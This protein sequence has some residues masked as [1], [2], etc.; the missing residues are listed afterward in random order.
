[1]FRDGKEAQMM[2]WIYG[3]DRLEAVREEEGVGRRKA[4]GLEHAWPDMEG[5]RGHLK[6][7]SKAKRWKLKTVRSAG[8]RAEGSGRGE[9][10]ADVRASPAHPAAPPATPFFFELQ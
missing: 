7:K 2:T 9:R 4:W 1:M 8:V 5:L 3:G 6:G 10:E